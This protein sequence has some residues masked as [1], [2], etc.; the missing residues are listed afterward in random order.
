MT[1]PDWSTLTPAQ[2]ATLTRSPLAT[3]DLGVELL[4]FDLTV[5]SDIT[6]Y[7]DVS[8]GDVQ[9][10]GSAL[11]HRDIAV[12]LSLELAWGI[13]LIRVYRVVTDT[14][15]G[16]SARCNR[17]VFCLTS[18]EHDLGQTVTAA[19]GTQQSIY[20]VTGQDRTYLLDRQPGYSVYIPIPCTV[21]SALDQLYTAAGVP[22]Y[23]VDS[24][25]STASLGAALTW[26]MIPAS[27]AASTDGTQTGDPQIAANGG[28][29]SGATWRQMINDVHAQVSY[30]AVWADEN[31]LL[32]STPYA[33]PETAPISGVLDAND[34]VTSI[35]GMDRKVTRDVWGIPN[36]WIF[37]WSNMPAGTAPTL[38]DG[39]VYI[40]DNVGDGPSSQS[41]RNGLVYS[42]TIS[43]TAVDTTS[44]I[45]QGDTRVAA[46]KRTVTTYVLKLAPAALVMLGHFTVLS[47]ADSDAG[48]VP[49]RVQ[50]A[51][52]TEHFDGSDIDVTL[53]TV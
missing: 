53:E 32:R 13:A 5:N 20:S 4:N 19:D 39:G 44:F 50:C 23:L 38:S 42:Q 36:R 35:V 14:V 15:T 30:R 16:L 37:T 49:V 11:V 3:I 8:A 43:L 12:N 34:P 33:S 10:T 31:G 18:P 7:A 40:V 6:A 26:P 51:A 46:D 45:T 27:T 24:S 1:A 25:S 2:L 21:A 29:S 22:G 41:A 47:L 48:G 28:E 9:W 52:W 17:G